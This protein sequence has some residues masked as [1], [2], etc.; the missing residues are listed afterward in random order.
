MLNQVA[1]KLTKRSEFACAGHATSAKVSQV[2]EIFMNV[3]F[4]DG[5]CVQLDH[6]CLFQPGDKLL[7]VSVIYLL[8]QAAGIPAVQKCLKV[9]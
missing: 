8:R 3:C 2:R 5:S 4:R 6:G 9:W 1:E 7:N